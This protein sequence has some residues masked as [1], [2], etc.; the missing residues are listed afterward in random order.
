MSETPNTAGPLSASDLLLEHRRQLAEVARDYSIQTSATIRQLAYAGIALCWLFKVEVGSDPG[1]PHQ[2]VIPLFLLALTLTCDLLH[3]IF[4]VA[5]G[6]FRVDATE[7]RQLGR[8]RATFYGIIH[9]HSPT[10]I[11]FWT[12]AGTLAAAYVVLLYYFGT[13]LV[14][15]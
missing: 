14:A 15:I 10:G 3:S 12:K 5:V 8:M 7:R 4:G 11:L 9:R 13:H 1:L 6:L 2:V